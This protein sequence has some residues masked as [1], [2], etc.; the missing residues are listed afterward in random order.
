MKNISYIVIDLEATC[1]DKTQ[2]QNEI[3][4]IGAIKLDQILS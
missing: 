1:D 3:I 4:E 2:I